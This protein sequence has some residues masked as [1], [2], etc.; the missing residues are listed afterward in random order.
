MDGERD[1]GLRPV[2]LASR[3]GLTWIWKWW[4]VAGEVVKDA[5]CR[6]NRKVVKLNARYGRSGV[7]ESKQETTTKPGG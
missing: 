4:L 2:G 1:G 5:V 3:L 6:A 7:D